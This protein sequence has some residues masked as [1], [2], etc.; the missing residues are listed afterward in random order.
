MPSFSIFVTNAAIWLMSFLFK[1]SIWLFFGELTLL[2]RQKG[3][4]RFFMCLTES[5]IAIAYLHVMRVASLKLFV[6]SVLFRVIHSLGRYRHETI[7][8]SAQP[9]AKHTIRLVFLMVTLFTI[10]LFVVHHFASEATQ[11]GKDSANF[12]ILFLLD[13]SLMAVSAI[14][15]LVKVYITQCGRLGN[16]SHESHH[17]TKFYVNVVL[18][19]IASVL[20]ILF[21]LALMTV[22]LPLHLIRDL[23]INL[24]ETRTNI[25]NLVNY[26]RLMANI[27]RVLPDATKEQLDKDNKCAICYDDM[28]EGT[29]CKALPCSH[30]FHRECLLRWFE[31]QTACVYCNKDVKGLFE[32]N[33][34]AR[35]PQQVPP[36]AAAAPNVQQP[37]PQPAQEGVPANAPQLFRHPLAIRA[38]LFFDD[39]HADL[40]NLTDE[41]LERE[42]HRVAA[43]FQSASDRG[44]YPPAFSFG[45]GSPASAHHS[46]GHHPNNLFS[47]HLRG[48]R[49]D[50]LPLGGP[51]PD[52]S[53]LAHTSDPVVLSLQVAAYRQYVS[54]SRLALDELDRTLTAIANSSAATHSSAAT[55]GPVP[56]Q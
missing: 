13:Y 47:S 6:F 9:M 40:D 25:R 3:V 23:F 43:Q 5:V 48:G 11:R 31:K 44:I 54:D 7:E 20:H 34:P 32:A 49:V 15:T 30:V 4:E 12:T 42:L 14:G 10:D 24:S 19:V 18:S 53:A 27:D 37:P 33:V 16:G 29:H 8:H 38:D 22:T 51:A 21:F 50:Y 55:A 1:I 56:P 52:I 36:A 35:Q 28:L 39:A 41:E 17:A 2:E 26:R 45:G 46:L